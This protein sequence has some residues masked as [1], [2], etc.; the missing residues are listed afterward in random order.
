MAKDFASHYFKFSWTFPLMFVYRIFYHT[1]YMS[2]VDIYSTAVLRRR[3]TP[4]GIHN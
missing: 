3:L 4:P 2:F 1:L